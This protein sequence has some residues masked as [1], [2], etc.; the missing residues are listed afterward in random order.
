MIGLTS[1]SSPFQRHA[2]VTLT[3]ACLLG[4]CSGGGTSNPAAPTGS[5]ATVSVA[6]VNKAV[7]NGGVA[8]TA[9]GEGSDGNAYRINYSVLPVGEGEFEGQRRARSVTTMSLFRNG[10]F[11]ATE[12]RTTYFDAAS[13]QP[14]GSTSGDPAM[15]T[16]SVVMPADPTGKAGESTMTAG[17]AQSHFTSASKSDLVA[18]S[19][20]T[21][22][23]EAA[24]AERQWACIDTTLTPVA[25]AGAGRASTE[26]FEVDAAGLITGGFKGTLNLHD[27]GDLVV[28]FVGRGRPTSGSRAG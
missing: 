27:A 10:M 22:R 16:Y 18:S 4:A 23:V 2:L 3:S 19:S 14:A 7:L 8:Y 26:C 13:G 17:A 25:Q 12:Q 15:G 20:S 6:A 1:F 11:I 5:A 9:S 21:W 28:Q 24:A